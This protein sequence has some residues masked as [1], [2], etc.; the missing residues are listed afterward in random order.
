LGYAPTKTS[1]M[2]ELRHGPGTGIPLL[3]LLRKTRVSVFLYAGDSG[4]TV[5]AKPDALTLNRS[6]IF[7]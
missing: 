5:G 7:H 1:H 6:R 2:P 3:P 4:D